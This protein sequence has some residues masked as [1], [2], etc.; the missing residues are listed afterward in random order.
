M[1]AKWL[2]K[3]WLTCV[4]VG[5]GC[6]IASAQIHGAGATFPAP[7]YVEWAK[8]YAQAGG[9]AVRYDAVGSGLGIEKIRQRE[10]DFGASDVPLEPAELAVS[11]LMQFP[12]VIGGVVPIINISGI[13]AGSLRL[14]GPLLAD[15]YL[16][17]IRKWS[18]SQIAELNPKL[19]LPDANITVVHR[20]DSSGSSL[21]WTDYLSHASSAWQSNVGASLLPVWP[22]G[23]G[24]IGNEGVASYVQR[25]RFALGYV[26][27]TYARSHRLSDASLR[28]H[29]GIFVR[30]QPEAFR[31]AAGVSNWSDLAHIRQ[32]RTDQ[33]G[34]DSWPITAATFVLLP[35]TSGDS[36]RTRAVLK[37]FDWALHRAA[38]IASSL[39]YEPIPNS[40]VEQISDLWRREIRDNNNQ[41]IWP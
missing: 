36:A 34:A 30:A 21:L 40:L 9:E 29:D 3:I 23:V 31:A 13:K 14:S 4:L 24:G 8:A 39:D 26:E 19:H 35:T 37:F 1:K 2:Y 17:R 6:E 33:P 12:V 16:G 32:L 15:I 20:S 10:V 28:N 11:N 7:L 25:T 38:A 5:C 27:Y 22:I 41:P 18:D